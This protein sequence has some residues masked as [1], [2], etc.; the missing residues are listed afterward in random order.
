MLPIHPVAVDEQQVL[1]PGS[2]PHREGEDVGAE[3]PATPMTQSGHE[4][5]DGVRGAVLIG[6]DA[7]PGAVDAMAFVLDRPSV[8]AGLGWPMVGGQVIAGVVA[9]AVPVPPPWRAVVV[10]FTGV[11]GIAEPVIGVRFPPLAQD[12]L[13]TAQHRQRAQRQPAR[14]HTLSLRKRPVVGG[15]ATSGPTRARGMRRA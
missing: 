12:Y 5:A 6:V 10:F 11:D 15:P 1:H 13:L 3:G 14:H 8:V 9:A 7:Q 4:Q 2:L